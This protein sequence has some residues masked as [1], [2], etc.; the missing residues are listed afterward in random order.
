MYGLVD[1]EEL[2][3]TDL[4]LTAPDVNREDVEI[5]EDTRVEVPDIGLF[6]DIDDVDERS[7]EYTIQPTIPNSDA[8]IDAPFESDT[9][10][11]NPPLDNDD[12]VNENTKK[13]KKR[14]LSPAE[15]VGAISR[16]PVVKQT[17][18]VKSL[19]LSEALAVP[20]MSQDYA[21]PSRKLSGEQEELELASKP[22][23]VEVVPS[24]QPGIV[25]EGDLSV[26]IHAERRAYTFG[27][28]NLRTEEEVQLLLALLEDQQKKNNVRGRPMKHNARVKWSST[29]ERA[30]SVLHKDVVRYVMKNLF[31]KKGM[32]EHRNGRRRNQYPK[33]GQVIKIDPISG[34][35]IYPPGHPSHG[36]AGKKNTVLVGLAPSDSPPPEICRSETGCNKD[37]DDVDQPQ[38][39]TSRAAGS[40]SPWS[41]KPTK[42]GIGIDCTP[43]TGNNVSGSAKALTATTCTADDVFKFDITPDGGGRCLLCSR[44]FKSLSDTRKHM[45]RMHTG[46]NI[47]ECILCGRFIPNGYAFRTHMHLIH[48]FKGVPN[49]IEGYGRRLRD[50]DKPVG[51]KNQDDD[52]D[53]PPMGSE[54]DQVEP[55]RRAKSCGK[56]NGCLKANCGECIY[57]KDMKSFGGP[58]IARKKCRRRRCTRMTLKRSKITEDANEVAEDESEAGPPPTKRG[59]RRLDGDV[60]ITPNFIS[61]HC[62]YCGSKFENWTLLRKHVRAEHAEYVQPMN[63]EYQ[64]GT[65]TSYSCEYCN[66]KFKKWQS[67]KR[68]M[69]AEHAEHVCEQCGL[70]L[71]DYYFCDRCNPKVGKEQYVS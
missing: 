22:D 67:L 4:E 42:L 25:G 43:S 56:C 47:Y 54:E 5:E 7:S 16:N 58:G 70:K 35:L 3:E 60:L 8:G 39:S 66:S 38:I 31:T 61:L 24:T 41:L 40:Q 28:V 14:K 19:S 44:D 34:E 63:V 49:V 1:E 37:N 62:K 17:A 13:K 20:V 36:M 65:A 10:T 12:S 33:R 71:P 69:M 53:P 55:R 32:K 27:P 15:R 46:G 50:V 6:D 26:S 9:H 21:G 52:S 45:E 57:C 48:G 11:V 2:P 18:P 68:H 29:A 64:Y 59:R 30:K 23:G 51:E